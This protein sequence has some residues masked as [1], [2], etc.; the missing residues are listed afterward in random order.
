MFCFSFRVFVKSELGIFPGLS[1]KELG[2]Q[3]QPHS[4]DSAVCWDIVFF[5]LKASH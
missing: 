1:L 2:G 5:F 3:D 4:V